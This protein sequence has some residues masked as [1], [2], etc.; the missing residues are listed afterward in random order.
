MIDSAHTKI[1]KRTVTTREG[2]KEGMKEEGK[3]E[4]VQHFSARKLTWTKETQ[5]WRQKNI[6]SPYDKNGEH[7][8]GFG[9][10]SQPPSGN[11]QSTLL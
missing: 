8:L 10:A 4:V 1:I 5:R 9:S 11:V 7:F 6:E 2:E 3:P